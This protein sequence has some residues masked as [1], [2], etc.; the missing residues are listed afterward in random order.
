M[1]ENAPVS[2]EHSPAKSI[3]LYLDES[4]DDAPINSTNKYPLGQP[5]EVLRSDGSWSLGTPE[6][7]ENLGGTYTVRLQDGSYKYM[8]EECDLRIPHFVLRQPL[9]VEFVFFS[10]GGRETS[11]QLHYVEVCD[12]TE[13]FC[14]TVKERTTHTELSSPGTRWILRNKSGVALLDVIVASR[15][16]VQR[17]MV[18]VEPLQSYYPPGNL[19]PGC[20]ARLSGMVNR[21]DLNGQDCLALWWVK[22]SSRWAI[23]LLSSTHDGRF[24]RILVRPQNIVNISIV[25]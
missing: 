21:P 19:C 9:T 8:V 24:E 2:L 22:E 11:A 17:H 6:E 13:K 5:A 12:K 1:R 16:Q 15:P 4:L 3:E 7:Y 23:Q 25:E 18:I 20:K 14:C 10:G